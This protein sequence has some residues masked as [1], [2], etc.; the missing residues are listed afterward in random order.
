MTSHRNIFAIL[1]FVGVLFV[2]IAATLFF[3]ATPRPVWTTSSPRV[4]SDFEFIGVYKGIPRHLE[5]YNIEHNSCLN[6]GNLWAYFH[7]KGKQIG[8]VY[9]RIEGKSGV[10]SA[11]TNM[12]RQSYPKP[13]EDSVI[14]CVPVPSEYSAEL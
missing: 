7:V 13:N 8:R 1:A 14:V 3:Y 9:S 4:Q 11:S 10:V 12:T 6:T 5:E 2:A